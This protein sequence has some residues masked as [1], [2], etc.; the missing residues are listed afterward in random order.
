MFN[1]KDIIKSS[2]K[3]ESPKCINCIH[4]ELIMKRQRMGACRNP[5]SE[6]DGKVMESSE[7]CDKFE[8]N[9]DSN[10]NSI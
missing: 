1:I 10:Y 6:L 7:I 4:F 9:E 5:K 2:K 8:K 3:D